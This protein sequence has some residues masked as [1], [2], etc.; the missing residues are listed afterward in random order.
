MDAKTASRQ[1]LDRLISEGHIAYL[2]GGCVR[3]RLLGQIPKDYDIATDAKPDQI[4]KLYPKADAIG[5]HF[6]VILVKLQGHHIEVA[7]FRSDGSYTDGR[8]P[9]T[10]AFTSP[11]EDAQRRDFSINGLFLD[12]KTDQ[13][14]DHV[15]G[16]ADLKARKLRA[17]GEPLAR[18]QEDYLRM[19]RAIRFAARFG[20]EIEPTTWQAICSVAPRI[21]EIAPERIQGELNLIL[22]SSSRLVGFD[23]LDQSGLLSYILPEIAALKGCAQPPQFHPEGDVFVH[24][25]MMLGKLAKDAPLPLVLSTL[26]H[27]IGKPGTQT[28]DEDTGRIRFNGHDAL[29]AEMAERILRRLRYPNETTEFVTRAVARHMQF[30]NVQ[31]M[32]TSTLKRFMAEEKFDWELE[33]HRVDCLSSNGNLE[34]H[35]YVLAKRDDFSQEPLIPKPLLDGRQL[36]EKGIKPGPMMGSIL[37]ECQDL[38]LEG[39]LKS[40]EQALEW[41]RKFLD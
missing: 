33:L 21:Q 4:L 25:R 22:S 8:R 37:K 34:N 32:R 13:I 14:I 18:F 15:G 2:A 11:E 16:Q 1:V 6:G 17:I 36:M 23:L 40:K 31:R 24:T 9:D 38:Q 26:F 7:T 10:I 12:P 30:M 29:G 41:L 28:R 20:F 19:L 5:A 3:D 27:D 35:E 39:A